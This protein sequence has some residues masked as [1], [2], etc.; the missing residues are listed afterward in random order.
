VTV[1][2]QVNTGAAQDTFSDEN[3]ASNTASVSYSTTAPTVSVTPSGTSTDSSPITF[4]LTFSE[5]VT[6]LTDSGITVTNGTL[7]TLSG[8]GTTY[9]VPVTPS[10]SGVTVTLQVDASAA[11]DVFGDENTASNTASVTYNAV[12]PITQL[13]AAAP[14]GATAGS[15]FNLIVQ[16]ED[17]L[18]NVVTAFNGDVTVSLLTNPGGSTLG[19]L[20]TVAAVKGVAEFSLT[21]DNAGVGYALSV[22]AQPGAALLTTIVSPFAVSPAGVP[23][24]QQVTAPVSSTD[25]AGNTLTYGVTVGGYSSLFSVEQQF[26][27]QAPAGAVNYYYG[28]HGPDAKFLYSGNGSNAS[29]G[30]YYFLMPNG[31]L[32]AWIDDSLTSSLGVSTPAGQPGTLAYDDPANLIGATPPY[33]STAASTEQ[34]YD[35]VAPPGASNYYFDARGALEKYL[36]SDNKSNSSQGGYYFIVP[37]GNLYAW[38]DNSLSSSLGAAPV[39]TLPTYYYQNP[40]YLGIA[41]AGAISGISAGISGG[42][43]SVTDSGYVGTATIFVAATTTTAPITTTYENFIVTFTDTAPSLGSLSNQTLP[44]NQQATAT[45]VASA[46]NGGTLTLTAQVGG[47]D[48]LYAVEQELDLQAP[49]GPNYFYN[50]RGAQENYLVSGNGS[51]PAGG[52]YYFIEPN[53]NMYAWDNSSVSTSESSP[54]A[55]ITVGTAAYYDPALI[56]SSSAPYIPFAYSTEQSLE[57]KAPPGPNYFYNARG[58]QE[59]YLVSGTSNPAGGGYYVIVPN[60]NLYAWDGVS[61]NTTLDTTPVVTLPTIYYDDPTQLVDIVPPGAL[62]GVVANIVGNSLTVTDTGF[63]GTATI[64]VTASDGLLS[65][66]Q[67]FLVTFTDS[68]PSNSGTPTSVSHTSSATE[69][70]NATDSAGNP[71]TYTAEVDGYSALFNFEQHY[72]LQAPPDPSGNYFYNQRG[73]GENYLVSGNGNNAAHGGYYILMPTGDVYPWDGNSISTSENG[74]VNSIG[75]VGV[76]VYVNPSLLINAQA[77]YNQTAYSTEQSLKLQAPPGPNFQFDARGEDEKYLVSG[78]S[79]LANGGYYVLMPN[80]NLYAWTDNSLAVTLANAPVATLPLLY[81]QNPAELIYSLPPGPL[82]GVSVNISAG[83]LTVSDPGGYIGTVTITLFV[84]DGVLT[85]PSTF[86]VTFS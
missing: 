61:I 41:G 32:Y 75:N 54:N 13:A 67:T 71:V 24:N 33:N 38:I 65:T 19:G 36:F 25:G 70:L 31:N 35:L 85:N 27:L 11:Q 76:S 15:A 83:T 43:L 22:Q 59:K 44:F 82:T 51:N 28:S 66:T 86:T 77:P 84:T 55:A 69:S 20:L 1:T 39:A 79:N 9:T 60:G 29:Q 2:L 8:S 78:N 52:G 6:G 37:N 14:V 57:L 17:K 40:A 23:Y 73:S 81:Y 12:S 10:A 64:Y 21:L 48:P 30:G 4:T 46:A 62:T 49:P 58:A 74:G 5:A 26:D 72:D 3:T 53:G 63:T 56:T 80:G 47:Y 18:G 34:T 68:P 42:T 45:L 50:A 16:A 7:G